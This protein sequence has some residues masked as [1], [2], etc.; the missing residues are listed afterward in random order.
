M[1]T[2]FTDAYMR[3][4]GEMAEELSDD[5]KAEVRGWQYHHAT[6]YMRR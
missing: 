1:L 4:Q 5:A 3:H 6:E 2:W